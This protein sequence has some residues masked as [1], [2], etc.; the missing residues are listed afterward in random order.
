MA[1]GLNSWSQTAA[2]N[3]TADSNVNFAEGMAPSAV[4]DSARALMASMAKWRDDNNGTITTGGTSTAYTATTNQGFGSLANGLTLRLKMSVTN[5]ASATL[6]VDSLGAKSIVTVPGVTNVGA[7]Q[8]IADSVYDFVYNSSTTQWVVVALAA[9]EFAT[10]TKTVFT[11]AAAPS[12][13]TKSSAL[14][15]ATLR[16]VTGS[17][18]GTGGTANFT[19]AFASRTLT[20]AN[21]PSGVTLTGSG[22]QS[23][24]ATVSGNSANGIAGNATALLTG[25][26]GS[27]VY[28]SNQFGSIAVS[29][30]NFANCSVS[31]G[32]S[33]TALD[34][35][36]KYL[37]AIDCTK[38]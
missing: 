23:L 33:G 7:G 28:A 30:V 3:A 25:T 27:N 9:S 32:G 12:G 31:L 34:F 20:Q 36:V 15:N 17:G 1:T 16:I 6:N 37:D 35:A 8:L 24:S 5:G 13:W 11:Q 2:S 26:N 29:D 22:T 4:N 38:A 21:L 10:G 14:D 18:G 19:T